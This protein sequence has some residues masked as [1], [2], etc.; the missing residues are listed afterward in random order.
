MPAPLVVFA[1]NR[2][3]HIKITLDCLNANELANQTDLFVF[4]D[5][6]KNEK[7]VEAVNAT[8]SVVDEF[9][10]DSAFHKIQV[11]KAKQN[12]GLAA[13]IIQGVTDIINRYGRV[14]VVEDDLMTSADFLS[15]M[16]NALDFY[17]KNP[18]VWSISGYT[19][20][21][22]SLEKYPHDIYASPRGCS[23]GWATWKDRFEKVDWNVSDFDEFIKDS[24]RKRHFNEGGPDMTEMLTRQVQGK[25]NSWAIR[26]CYQ[27]SKENM[28]TIYPTKSRVRNIGCDDS[29]T[30]CVSSNLYD[31][32]LIQPGS[33]CSFEDLAP[34]RKIMR[35]FR[36]MY[37]Y[38]HFGNLRR[39]IIRALSS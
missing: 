5:Q 18:K 27:E 17:E 29:G 38:S 23:W 24:A 10:K 7:A 13:S 33:S 30:H 4:C 3:D 20:P 21:L 25:I 39:K 6:A 28:Y 1:Y 15:Y 9:A 11:I 2:A 8:R 37:D 34:D 19:S 22:K 16:N 32:T 35:E 26:W 12:K 36:S 31:T 14:I